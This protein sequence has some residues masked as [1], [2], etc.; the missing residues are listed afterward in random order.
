MYWSFCK[1]ENESGISTRPSII[2]IAF[3]PCIAI[4][5]V[6]LVTSLKE[7]EYVIRCSLIFN[8]LA[9]LQISKILSLNFQNI[10]S[11]I[12]QPLLL[13]KIEYKAFPTCKFSMSEQIKFCK[14]AISLYWISNLPICETSKN[15]LSSLT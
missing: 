6:E 12:A 2:S 7:I 9:A 8:V 4:N 13:V 15:P 1:H 5:A 10:T 14:I 11:S 3:G